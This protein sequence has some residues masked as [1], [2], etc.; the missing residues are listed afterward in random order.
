[1][2]L[3][4]ELLKASFRGAPWPVTYHDTVDTRLNHSSVKRGA[5]QA[6][7][8]QGCVLPQ[9]VRNLSLVCS[10]DR[11][12]WEEDA[13]MELRASCQD[14]SSQPD[15]GQVRLWLVAAVSMLLGIRQA[16]TLAP[17]GSQNSFGYWHTA[18]CHYPTRAIL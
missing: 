15:A 18:R 4:S 6:A 14:G 7:T 1:M 12:V 3:S 8:N 17:G 13:A 9:A 16:P 5:L 10:T 11:D 2:L